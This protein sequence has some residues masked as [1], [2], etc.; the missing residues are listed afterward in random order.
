MKQAA[1][2]QTPPA[3][4]RQ[5][6]LSQETK[7]LQATAQGVEK[8]ARDAERGLRFA[9]SFNAYKEAAEKYKSLR[10]EAAGNEILRVWA[11][12]RALAMLDGAE[13]LQKF[14]HSASNDAPTV[15]ENLFN[16]PHVPGSAAA[17]AQA[18]MPE[19]FAKPD[20]NMPNTLPNSLTET[21]VRGRTR[22]DAAE[23]HVLIVGNKING[24]VYERMHARCG[25]Y[26]WH[27]FV[28]L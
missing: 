4:Q 27:T 21:F 2:T 18:R 26:V 16:L 17:A 9:I 20:A 13:R 23:E 14:I 12:E 15:D 25:L 5:H 1:K 3:A 10:Q 19:N 28:C 7:M 24:K 11:G 22:K 8:R 6:V